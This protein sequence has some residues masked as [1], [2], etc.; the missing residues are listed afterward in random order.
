MPALCYTCKLI[1]RISSIQAHVRL[2]VLAL[3]F[4]FRRVLQLPPGFLQDFT[5]SS[6]QA[7]G[8]SSLYSSCFIFFLRC[9]AGVCLLLNCLSCLYIKGWIRIHSFCKWYF[10]SSLF[11]GFPSLV[12]CFPDIQAYPLQIETLLVFPSLPMPFIAFLCRNA[13]NSNSSVI[14]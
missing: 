11:Y 5:A 13:W 1:C 3:C 14:K 6:R 8:I 7:S 4:C 12:S 10:I 9:H 2:S